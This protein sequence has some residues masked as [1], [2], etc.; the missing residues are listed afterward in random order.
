MGNSFEITKNNVPTVLSDLEKA[1][2]KALTEIGIVVTGKAKVNSPV[3]TGRL[4]GSI[5][6]EVKP[7]EKA[8]YIGTNVEYAPY[9]EYGHRVGTSG[10]FVPPQPYLKPAVENSRSE[11]KSI[12][13][14][15]LGK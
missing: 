15:N 4:R 7:S 13:E 14:E 10:A 2:I 6:N 8:V 9:V 12:V 3:D 1:E 11:I 5:T